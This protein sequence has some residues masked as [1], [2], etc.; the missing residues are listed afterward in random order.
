MV[1]MPSSQPADRRAVEMIMRN[2]STGVAVSRPPSSRTTLRH[3]PN[4]RARRWALRS[5]RINRLT[6]KGRISGVKFSQS[7]KPRLD[8]TLPHHTASRSVR[9]LNGRLDQGEVGDARRARRLDG[10][11]A[12]DVRPWRTP[13]LRHV[14]WLRGRR[15]AL[16][17]GDRP[18]RG[19]VRHR[20]LGGA[21]RLPRDHR[22]R[23]HLRR[24]RD[25]QPDR[26]RAAGRAGC[27]RRR[28]QRAPG[29]LPPVPRDIR[30]PAGPHQ[31][32]S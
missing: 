13:P 25:R 9:L 4:A 16:P 6:L 3:R 10:L 31:F 1:P 2:S 26:R 27:G 28:L 19:P 21:A 14:G 24:G 22:R 8:A 17:T 32:L 30:S 18:G 23:R 7:A 20:R 5:D 29:D 15:A 12:T 11:R